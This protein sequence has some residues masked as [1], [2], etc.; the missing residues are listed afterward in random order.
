MAHGTARRVARYLFLDIET[1]PAIHWDEERR[2]AYAVKKVP[3][4]YKKP[5]AIQKWM[6]S[7]GSKLWQETSLNP[8]HGRLCCV[9]FALDG[10]D[11]VLLWADTP[12]DER[13][14]LETLYEAINANSPRLVAH[15]G[16]RFDFPWL[17]TRAMA[18]GMY[19]LAQRLKK[20]KPWAST[21]VDTYYSWTEGARTPGNMTDLCELLG[22]ED[23]DTIS[24]AD[25]YRLW[26]TGD[27]ADRKL[28]G[29]HCVQDVIKLRALFLKLRRGGYI[30]GEK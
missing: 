7:K 18:H 15:N 16:F 4:N 26:A 30:E 23:N 1:L 10:D 29:D 9:S 19:G 25:V 6:D 5:E 21:L 11:P 17:R 12:E 13:A 20:G 14:A 3:A 24:G 27:D 28:I 22:I 8:L 2:A